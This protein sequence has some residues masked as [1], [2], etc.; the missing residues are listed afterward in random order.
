VDSIHHE[1][2]SLSDWVSTSSGFVDSNHIG[3]TDLTVPDVVAFACY[4]YDHN[5][6]DADT[7]GTVI[8]SITTDSSRYVYVYSP[9]GG[10]ESINNQRHEGGWDDNKARIEVSDARSIDARSVDCVI[11]GLQISFVSAADRSGINFFSSQ[12]ATTAKV[13][14]NIVKSF[15]DSG[16]GSGCIF[17]EYNAHGT[18]YAIN[19]ICL[20]APSG[21]KCGAI[22]SNG[23][24]LTLHSYN[25]TIYQSAGDGVAQYGGT[26]TAENCV[27][28]NNDGTDYSGTITVTYSASDDTISGTGNIDWNNGA[29]DWAANFTDYANGD[30]S[31]KNYTTSGIAVIEQGTDLRSEG[32]WRD[33]RGEERD[34]STPDIGAFE[35]TL[36]SIQSGDDYQ[37]TYLPD[38]SLLIT[39]LGT[40]A[41]GNELEWDDTFAASGT[42]NF[43]SSIS[44]AL[45]SSDSALLVSR[46]LISAIN[47]VFSTSDITLSTAQ[48]IEF[49]SAISVVLATT[50]IAADIQRD[51]QSAI[52]SGFSTT[53]INFNV[54]RDLASTLSSIFST[55]DITLESLISLLSNISIVSNSSDI[56]LRIARLLISVI[57][58]NFNTSDAL[59]KIER[60]LQSTITAISQTSEADLL[61]LREFLTSISSVISTSDITLDITG[62]ID[63]ISSITSTFNSSDIAVNVLRNVSSNINS[64]SVTSNITLGFLRSLVSAISTTFETSDIQLQRLYDLTAAISVATTTSDINLALENLVDFVSSISVAF[65]TENCDL[66]VLRLLDSLIASAVTTADI[67]LIFVIL[68]TVFG[69][70]MIEVTDEYN[71]IET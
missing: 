45:S 1:F 63:F 26:V 40:V 25:N 18:L 35:R 66:V 22:A 55:S 15:R 48:I 62:F 33:I 61:V 42:I 38:G 60:I 14:N 30:F 7:T 51:L 6:H 64:A 34:E 65:A 46:Q 13:K 44:A 68:G 31:L 17:G 36:K 70:N 23:L 52:N 37:I 19:N 9:T 29:T 32:I 57:S 21:Y 27:S 24:Y 67:H 39:Q 43:I 53:N 11:E 49:I 58:S 4:Y 41:T 69:A 2:A 71:V 50:D 8:D 5:A 56:N 28:F 20:D 47:S 10:A 54:V 12:S 16:N 59:I 3:N